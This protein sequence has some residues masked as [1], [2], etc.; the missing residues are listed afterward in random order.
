MVACPFGVPRYEW[1]SLTPRV[2]KCTMC[3][4]RITDGK[5]PAC[6]E[7]CPAEAV[8]FGTRKEILNEAR[9]RILEQPDGY[10]PR[11][12]GEGI[13]GG[14]AVYYLAAVPF[15][16][17]AFKVDLGEQPMP[18]LTWAALSKIPEVITLGGATMMGLFWIVNRRNRRA[19]EVAEED[20]TS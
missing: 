4:E 2:Q 20:F 19:R 12:Y 3:Y 1:D 15:E 11:I 6:A 14:T 7:A 9:R 13:V 18:E 8:T 16:Q 17:L 10:V 5:I